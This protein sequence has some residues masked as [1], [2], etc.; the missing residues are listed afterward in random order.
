[1]TINFSLTKIVFPNMD[2][3]TN[4]A[5]QS[6]CMCQKEQVNIA[7][8]GGNQKQLKQQTNIAISTLIIL[9]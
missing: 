1:M 3:M 2:I 9:I 5:R 6:Y 8:F 7:S 4:M